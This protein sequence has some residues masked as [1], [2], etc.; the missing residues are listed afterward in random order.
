MELLGSSKQKAGSASSEAQV[1][2][3]TFQEQGLPWENVLDPS[4]K[5][6][7]SCCIGKR[8]VS[9]RERAAQVEIV[10]LVIVCIQFISHQERRS[11]VPFVYCYESRRIAYVFQKGFRV[12]GQFSTF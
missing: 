2:I 9:Y 5:E 12:N 4:R 8:L 6:R 10:I 7:R 1:D 11:V 3:F